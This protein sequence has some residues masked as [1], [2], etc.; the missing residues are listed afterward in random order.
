MVFAFYRAGAESQGLTSAS[1]VLDHRDFPWAPGVGIGASMP[2][3][4]FFPFP[5]LFFDEGSKG[6]DKM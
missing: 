4:G 2:Q 6:G 5:R 1:Q 3:P